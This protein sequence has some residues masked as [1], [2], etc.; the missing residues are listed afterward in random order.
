MK[1]KSAGKP[2]STNKKAA[3]NVRGRKTK[4]GKPGIGWPK[5]PY[6]KPKTDEERLAK[7]RE[8][9][10]DLKCSKC[11][12]SRINLRIRTFK[13]GTEHIEAMCG[14]CE[15]HIRFLA[16]YSPA[17]KVTKSVTYLRD[18]WAE[19][20]SS[21]KALVEEIEAN[22]P[23][24]PKSP[25]LKELWDRYHA[26]KTIL[27]RGKGDPF[28]PIAPESIKTDKGVGMLIMHQGRVCLYEFQISGKLVGYEV[29]VLRFIN[30]EWKLPKSSDWGRNGWTCETYEAAKKR[31]ADTVEGLADET[32]GHGGKRIDPRVYGTAILSCWD[33][34]EGEVR[35][36]SRCPKMTEMLRKSYGSLHRVGMHHSGPYCQIFQVERTLKSARRV[37]DRL[38]EKRLQEASEVQT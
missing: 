20:S 1:K 34:G 10:P 11:R 33:F 9:N 13:N 27:E 12:D 18:Q 29:C 7:A 31:F 22:P 8:L 24:D 5:V 19:L 21:Q 14:L 23:T 32:E 15:K 2:G 26:V 36:Q 4:R 37:V 25:K 16:Y 17:E 38:I 35:I 30:G 6:G 28:K 3:G